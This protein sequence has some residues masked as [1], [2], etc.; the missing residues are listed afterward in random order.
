MRPGPATS[1][2][3][4]SASAVRSI[5]A[6]LTAS[7]VTLV[8]SVAHVLRR[9]QNGG[10][11]ED[12]ERLERD[13]L[14]KVGNETEEIPPRGLRLRAMARG[15]NSDGLEIMFPVLHVSHFRVG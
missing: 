6:P 3:T 13:R 1:A 8:E 5:V 12:S 15:N 14:V 2:L 9:L 7:P 10:G 11:P 4:P